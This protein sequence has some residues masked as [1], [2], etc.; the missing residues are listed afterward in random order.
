MG[1][2][3]RVPVKHE[4]GRESERRLQCAGARPALEPTMMKNSLAG[5]DTLRPG[6]KV[7]P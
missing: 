5:L 2:R 6:N 1:L 7:S 4:A 3:L